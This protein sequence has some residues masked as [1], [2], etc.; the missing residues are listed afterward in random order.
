MLLY[1]PTQISFFRLTNEIFTAS[2][3]RR[4]LKFNE[5]AKPTTPSMMGGVHLFKQRQK[6]TQGASLYHRMSEFATRI[7]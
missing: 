7:R 1:S 6:V 2:I 4:R 5:V 3:K